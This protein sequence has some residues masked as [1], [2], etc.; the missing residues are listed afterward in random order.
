MSSTTWITAALW[1]SLLAPGLAQEPAPERTDSELAAARVAEA[2][3]LT[4]AVLERDLA[5]LPRSAPGSWRDWSPKAPVPDGLGRLLQAGM[6]AYFAGEYVP[7]LAAYYR[8]LEVEPDFPPA[9]Y[10]AGTTHF[11]LRRYGDAILFYERFI[12][13][14]PGEVGA[15]QALGHS[16]YSLGRY[17]ESRAH[18]ERVLAASPGAVEA[19]RGLALSSYR[20]GEPERALELL[21]EV[22]AS[23]PDHTDALTWKAHVLFELDRLEPALEAAL[24]ARDSDAFQPRAW[25]LLSGIYTDLEREAEAAEARARFEELDRIQQGVRAAEGVLLHAPRDLQVR[26][27][28]V[29]LHRSAGDLAR[30]KAVLDE[31]VAIA[32]EELAVRVLVLDT[33]EAM[34]DLDGAETAALDLSANCAS[35]LM[36]WRRLQLYYAATGD[37]HMEMTTGERFLRM[38]DAAEAARRAAEEAQQE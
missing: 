37:R 30:V 36:T 15:T 14:V 23:R 18:Y 31:M 16:L 3:R 35:E 17:E 28:L 2:E 12:E 21:D 8:L 34:G 22:L 10:Q 13:V 5:A 29:E 19:K 38:R 24:A 9:L 11:R 33:L 4:A 6:G 27:R 26:A 1:A 7:A 32:P 25:F 20:V